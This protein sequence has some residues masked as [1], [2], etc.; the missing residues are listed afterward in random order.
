MADS[1]QKNDQEKLFD[2]LIAVKLL[3]KTKERKWKQLAAENPD[4]QRIK[5]EMQA[6]RKRI[7]GIEKCISKYGESFFDVY[8]SELIKPLSESDILVLRDEIKDVRY[9]LEAMGK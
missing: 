4:Y 5:N 3:Y 8:D 1:L 7:S 2:E 6:L 9:S